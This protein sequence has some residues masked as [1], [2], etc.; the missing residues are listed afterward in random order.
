MH[1]KARALDRHSNV[2]SFCSPLKL[3]IIL[4]TK[5]THNGAV[6]PP[7]TLIVPKLPTIIKP[8]KLTPA[9]QDLKAGLDGT[10]DDRFFSK[11]VESNISR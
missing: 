6:A 5:T 7:P 4:Q 1:L 11:P 3:D 2:N 10:F 9:Q 8:V